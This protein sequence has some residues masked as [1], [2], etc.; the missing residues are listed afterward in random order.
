MDAG[1]E[2]QGRGLRR[3][4]SRDKALGA[5]ALK[6]VGLEKQNLRCLFHYTN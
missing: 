6:K 3:V 1:P 5:H 4:Q 2:P